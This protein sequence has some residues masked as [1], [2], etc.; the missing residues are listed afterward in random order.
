MILADHCVFSSTI[1]FL[2]AAGYGVRRLKELA[3]TDARDPEVLNLARQH[4]LLLLTNDGDFGN[5]LLYPPA[6]HNGVIVLKIHAAVEQSVHRVLL[7]LLQE[8]DREELRH[9]LAVVDSRK[10]R[11]RAG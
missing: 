6:G 11:I 2:Q 10:Y 3:N 1:R 8:R 9:T 7:R 5:V 4:D